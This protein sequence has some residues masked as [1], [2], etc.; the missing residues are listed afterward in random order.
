MPSETISAL[1]DSITAFAAVAAL[2]FAYVQIR[3]AAAARDLEFLNNQ[4][5]LIGDHWRKTREA[6]SKDLGN[7]RFEFGEMLDCY[8]RTCFSLN[9]LKIGAK[10]YDFFRDHI[11]EVILSIKGDEFLWKEMES[12]RS[13]PRTYKEMQVFLDNNKQ[14]MQELRHARGV[15]SV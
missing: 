9:R 14:H 4:R 8:E 3:E 10:T 7:G 13:G 12:L 1:A 15:L 11:L 5:E 6:Y 2:S